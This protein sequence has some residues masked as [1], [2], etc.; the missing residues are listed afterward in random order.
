MKKNYVARMLSLLMIV[1]F[2]LTITSFKSFKK[3]PVKRGITLEKIKVQPPAFMISPQSLVIPVCTSQS[4]TFQCN[5]INGVQ[6][7]YR[8][9][10]TVGPGWTLASGDY[11]TFTNYITLTSIASNTSTLSVSVRVVDM[12]TSLIYDGGIGIVG[13]QSFSSNAVI[14]GSGVTVCNGGSETFNLTGLKTGETLSWTLS[15]SNL[16]SIT[17]VTGTQVTV[18][19]N[20]IGDMG[21]LIATITNSCGQSVQKKYQLSVG[22]PSFKEFVCSSMEGNDFCSG[23]VSVPYS[24][25]PSLNIGDKIT[26]SFTGMTSAERNNSANW[27]WERINSIITL[28]KTLNVARIGMMNFGQTGVRVRAKNACG[29]SAWQQLD[30]EID[31]VPETISKSANMINDKYEIYPNPASDVV[32]VNLKE[33]EFLDSE[34]LK[35]L[36]GEVYDMQGNLKK[37]FTLQGKKNTCINVK[38][39]KKGVYLLKLNT[40]NNIENHRIVVE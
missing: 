17:N 10:W 7:N 31:E 5:L 16:V 12:N 8:Y 13:K 22:V 24:Y 25:L 20:G 2:A 28:S 4:V 38:D 27:E 1:F 32:N 35:N 3:N 37:K 34:K 39:L 33:R 19:Y 30:F 29:W 18:S 14:N 23:S 9:F 15:Q 40:G 11:P 21:D 6:G 36:Q 26:A